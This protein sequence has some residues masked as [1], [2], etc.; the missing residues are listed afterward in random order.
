M[1]LDSWFWKQKSFFIYD[2]DRDDVEC[3]INIIENG[4]K[5]EFDSKR[6]QSIR[7]TVAVM[8]EA[9]MIHDWIKKRVGKLHGGEEYIRYT[10][11]KDLRETCNAILADHSK[12]RKLLPT[13]HGMKYDEEYFESV[14][15][16]ADELSRLDIRFEPCV[17]YV[18][19]YWY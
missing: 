6:L 8:R 2:T 3:S 9:W 18:Y 5:I 13:R 10:D 16:L 1:G 12:A 15:C 14:Q 11:L 19:G 17:S 4:K 7:E